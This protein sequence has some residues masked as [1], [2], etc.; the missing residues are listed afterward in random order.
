MTRKPEREF[1]V[2]LAAFIVASVV[3][4]GLAGTNVGVNWAGMILKV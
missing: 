3:V 2:G 4:S 1:A